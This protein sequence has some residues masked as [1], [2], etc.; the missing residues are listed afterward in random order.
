[1]ARALAVVAEAF[2]DTA[3]QLP[4]NL[5]GEELLGSNAPYPDY[6]A[7]FHTTFSPKAGGFCWSLAEKSGR[8]TWNYW[9]RCAGWRRLWVSSQANLPSTPII[10]RCL[11]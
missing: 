9:Q 5:F 7:A 6:L 8:C 10:R 3:E 11:E 4:V 1:M 2:R